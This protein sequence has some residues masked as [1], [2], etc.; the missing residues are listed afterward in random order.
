MAYII[1]MSIG[2]KYD[3]KELHMA[4]ANAVGNN[5][6]VVA[7]AGNDDDG[8][9][10]TTEINYPAAYNECISV[11]SISNDIDISRFSASNNELDLLAP[12]QGKGGRGIVSLAPGDKYVELMGT[13]MATPH[14]SGALALLKNY[15]V[16]EFARDM[17]E[18]ELYAQLIKRTK[19]LGFKKSAEGNG[20]LD[21]RIG[22]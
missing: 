13:S 4:I 22:S 9:F 7:A 15:G 1:S 16:T 17:T 8:N 19:T 21:L 11:G 3:S 2:G 14:V 10:V 5:I 6:L 12:G 20:M 18:E